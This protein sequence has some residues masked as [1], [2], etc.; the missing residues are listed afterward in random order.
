MG[1]ATRL[2]TKEIR[3][4]EVVEPVR[5]DHRSWQSLVARGSAGEV[6]GWATAVTKSPARLVP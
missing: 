4:V 3:M 6:Q 5:L 1:K 2:Y